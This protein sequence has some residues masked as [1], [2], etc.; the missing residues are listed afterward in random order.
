[1]ARFANDTPIEV[2]LSM[3]GLSKAQ[4]DWVQKSSTIRP[5]IRLKV[6]GIAN[7]ALDRARSLAPVGTGK[8]LSK[9]QK[10][11]GHRMIPNSMYARPYENA[12]VIGD[13]IA[14]PWFTSRF[15]EKGINR[16]V[17]VRAYVRKRG[18]KQ[19]R[20]AARSIRARAK[21]M[22]PNFQVGRRY[23]RK[24]ENSVIAQLAEDPTVNQR[25]LEYLK[26][27]GSGR[28][29]EGKKRHMKLTAR[30][31]ISV[32]LREMERSA[33]GEIQSAFQEWLRGD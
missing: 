27:K 7:R 31:H 28:V 25:H 5:R 18:N 2:S 6:L 17:Q 22:N 21:R 23:R 10:K 26:R 1:M 3:D 9:T 20:D 11:Y 13:R 19:T 4:A 30:P 32:A 8:L 29:T 24:I 33:P 14:S 16:D 15:F 12:D